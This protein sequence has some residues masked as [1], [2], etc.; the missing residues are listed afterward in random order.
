MMLRVVYRNH[1]F[2]ILIGP[3]SCSLD[4]TNVLVEVLFHG[5]KRVEQIRQW[6]QNLQ[7]AL[8]ARWERRTVLDLAECDGFIIR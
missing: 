1:G 5:E 4:C 7:E 3:Q 2:A 8:V 6:A